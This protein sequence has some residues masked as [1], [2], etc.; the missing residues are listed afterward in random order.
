V[1]ENSDLVIPTFDLPNNVSFSVE[2]VFQRLLALLGV[3]FVG[4]D[5][6]NGEFL[7]QLKQIIAYPF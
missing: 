1:V 3:W 4:P 7:F 5:G 6:R 2:D